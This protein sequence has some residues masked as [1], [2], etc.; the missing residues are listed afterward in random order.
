MDARQGLTPSFRNPL[1]DPMTPRFLLS[2]FCLISQAALLFAQAGPFA[3]ARDAELRFPA[4]ALVTHGV[5]G[6]TNPPSKLMISSVTAV[7]AQGGRLALVNAQVW[8]QRFHGPFSSYDQAVALAVDTT[9]NVLVTGNSLDLEPYPDFATLKYSSDGTPLWTNRY[10]GA[11]SSYSAVRSVALDAAGNAFVAGVSSGPGSSRDIVL[12]KYASD[13]T[14]V[15]TNRYN[16]FGTNQLGA[17]GLA[18]DGTGSALVLVASFGDLQDY[19]LLKY[20]PLGNAVWTNHYRASDR[21][22]DNPT[23]LAVDQVNN[24]FVVGGSSIQSEGSFVV[25]LKYA[26]DGTPLWTNRFS[27][28]LDDLPAALTVDSEG[29]AVVTGDLMIGQHRYFTLKYDT[30]GVPLWTNVIGAPD[31]QGGNVPRVVTDLHGNVFM[32]GGSPGADSTNVDFTTVKFSAAGLPLWTNRLFYPN[33]NNPA[34]GGI[35]VDTAGNFYFGG[36]TT[37]FGGTNPTWLTLKFDAGGLPVWTNLYNG[38]RP[39]LEWL[40]DLFVDETGAAYATGQSGTVGGTDFATVKYADQLV[41]RPPANFVGTDTFTFT[42]TDNLGRSAIGLASVIV[43]PPSLEF[44]T[45]PSVLHPSADG[46]AL[47]VDGAQGTNVVV[48]YASTNL[49]NWLPVHTNVPVQ[50]SVRFVDVGAPSAPYRFYR[51]SQEQ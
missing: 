16:W 24:V 39:G 14:Q 9:G 11:T 41:Y 44:N 21:G 18:V 8:A 35:A 48:I 22:Y 15:W 25:T 3:T 2:L 38:P 20:G 49:V 19:T 37:G 4:A 23:A 33:Q 27:L 36:H 46:F 40:D 10:P 26:G 17:A 32:T 47:Q 1:D 50:G 28:T 30:A 45:S 13:G 43:S 7:S 5:P 42:A 34:P 31:Y 29:N 12:V 6:L 51:A